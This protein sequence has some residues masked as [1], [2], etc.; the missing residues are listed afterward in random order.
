M[1]QE[2]L[3]TSAPR[4]LK[5]G[6]RGFCTVMSSRGLSGPLATAL[7][8]LSGY[9][10]IFT[11]DDPNASL[12]PVAWMHLTAAL[13]GKT[14]SILSRVSDY[15]LDY[16]QRTNKLAHHML[17]EGSD[18]VPAGPAWVLSQ[19]GFMIKE[20]EGEPRLLS[21]VRRIPPGDQAAV[22]CRKWGEMT[23]DQAWAGV[24]AECAMSDPVRPAILLFKPGQ[25]LL[26]LMQEALSLLPPERRWKATFCTYF[27]NL[28][29]TVNCAW[30]CLPAD[31]PEAHQ[32]RR[33]VNALRIDLTKPLGPAPENRF[34][35]QARTGQKPAAPKRPAV[36][37][38]G[39]R[40][41]T[42]PQ[43]AGANEGLADLP[44]FDDLPPD[45][46]AVALPQSHSSIST[47]R[48]EY[49]I[50]PPVIPDDELSDS[51]AYEELEES[52]E[53]RGGS[54]SIVRKVLIVLA[55]VLLFS[56]SVTGAY[57][58]YPMAL[59]AFNQIGNKIA[60][61]EQPEKQEESKEQASDTSE[62]KAEGEAKQEDVGK[63]PKAE[64]K[65]KAETEN[66]FAISS[67]VNPVDQDPDETSKPA[68]SLQ[69]ATEARADEEKDAGQTPE[70]VSPPTPNGNG[71]NLSVNIGVPPSK[72]MDIDK[73]ER[74]QEQGDQPISEK[75]E[76]ISNSH[77]DGNS[78]EPVK[79][80][81]EN[82]QKDE[83]T[84]TTPQTKIEESVPVVHQDDLHSVIPD[85]QVNTWKIAVDE[86]R[87]FDFSNVYQDMT[88]DVFLSHS[89]EGWRLVRDVNQ[90]DG[91]WPSW[92]IFYTLSNKSELPFA[93]VKRRPSTSY[94]L[95][96]TPPP[97]GGNTPDRNTLVTEWKAEKERL[98]GTIFRFSFAEK[99]TLYG[100]FR[101][102]LQ[103]P[104]STTETFFE[105]VE[106]D[107]FAVNS[108]IDL[109]GIASY[110]KTFPAD[111]IVDIHDVQFSGER[112]A[113]DTTD[114]LRISPETSPAIM[115][116]E[117]LPKNAKSERK[118]RHIEMAFK[119]QG[120]EAGG[121]L[122]VICKN[123]R[124]G[125]EMF[126]EV[127]SDALIYLRASID[128]LEKLS[129]IGPVKSYILMERTSVKIK[130]SE[131]LKTK[132][133]IKRGK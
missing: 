41:G 98:F 43:A 69:N 45:L 118:P 125:D 82:T 53:F 114:R 32:S 51:G 20:W 106:G 70:K 81:G 60:Q 95:I 2:L 65:D 116:T 110:S 26:P 88:L 56:A 123:A 71:E 78:P 5:P 89:S 86:T 19:P 107:G 28:P 15:G 34:A 104:L 127:G 18:L 129:S 54:S 122:Q 67:P 112:F 74:E 24:L 83:A 30:R 58:I 40:P 7:E 42:R 109:S 16:S 94:Y 29:Q 14:Y 79:R 17:L 13:G 126:D 36:Q 39:T 48:S 44:G 21:E 68:N 76:S 84:D 64:S 47:V 37:P 100:E 61:S 87:Q 128:V 63:T 10:Q 103:K 75:K 108:M 91:E 50:R 33:M 93:H 113:F 49:S 6:S 59:S 121:T 132:S 85:S 102:A 57:F 105:K 90:P 52:G 72:D 120:V 25:D 101:D 117:I 130:F 38:G 73:G 46:G 1:I 62:T 96:T 77:D 31:S 35:N 4:G 8:S 115:L 92:T 66:N 22:P 97:P 11:P 27:T 55:V 9:R 119:L 111:L 133:P 12:N 99:G 124:N 3:Y 131:S 23:G 80:D